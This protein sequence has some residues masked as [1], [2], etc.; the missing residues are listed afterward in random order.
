MQ[1]LVKDILPSSNPLHSQINPEQK[2]ITF[3]VVTLLDNQAYRFNL[4]VE[5][6]L[7]GGEKLQ[8]IITDRAFN[9]I[10]RHDLRIHRDIC[11]LVFSYH[12]HQLI[13]L[14]AD[15]GELEIEL[16]ASVNF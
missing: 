4:A 16:P 1:V 10:F 8:S 7:V 15:L 2:L 3:E 12:N 14:P 5:S 9:D 13:Q 11:Q 6:D